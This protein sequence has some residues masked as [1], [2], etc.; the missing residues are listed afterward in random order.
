MGLP[1]ALRQGGQFLFGTIY[2][3]FEKTEGYKNKQD[4]WVRS[5]HWVIELRKQIVLRGREREVSQFV[6]LTQDQVKLKLQEKYQALEGT[7]V[8]LPVRNY[9]DR[10]LLDGLDPISLAE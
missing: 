7:F 10:L 8:G 4:E 1:V 6:T 5:K 2:E 3:V 9:Y